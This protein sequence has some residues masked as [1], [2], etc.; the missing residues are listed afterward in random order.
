MGRLIHFAN[1][2]LRL[3]LP[4]TREN[5]TTVAIKTLPSV[6]KIEIRRILQSLYG[7][8][9]ERVATLNY[10]GKKKRSRYGMYRQPDY[11]KA[12]VYLRAPITLPE[13][14]FPLPQPKEK[15][16][17]SEKKGGATRK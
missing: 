7:L 3:M 13:G 12:Y 9:V 11:K 5:I 1:I 6:N 4:A 17:E 2:P 14:L 8:D 10:E 16:A 15:G